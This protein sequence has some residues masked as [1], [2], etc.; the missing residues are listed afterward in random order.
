MLS[1]SP[2]LFVIATEIFLR[3]LEANTSSQSLVRAYADDIALVLQNIWRVVPAVAKLFVNLERIAGLRLKPNKCVLIPLWSC[4]L[5][6]NFHILL[7]EELPVWR[8]FAIS[9]KGKYLGVWL[10][11]GAVDTSWNEP[12]KKYMAQCEYIASL[13]L[14]MAS[15]AL[16]YR[17]FALPVLSFILQIYQIPEEALKKERQALRLLL[18]GPGNWLSTTAIHNLDLLFGMP[19]AFPS[20][21]V[22]SIAVKG[23]VAILE[24][25]DLAECKARISKALGG[26]D[27][28]IWHRW[29]PWFR[30]S[31]AY[32]ISEAKDT[33]DCMGWLL[34]AASQGKTR[35][36]ATSSTSFQSAL[37]RALR[38]RTMRTDLSSLLRQR[39]QR[40][41]PLLDT[42]IGIAAR[43]GEI[44]IEKLK[45]EVP[46][47]VLAALVRSW[48]NGWCTARRFQQGRGSC[49]LAEECAGEDSLEH[50]CRCA[51]SWSGARSRLRVDDSRRQLGRFLLLETLPQD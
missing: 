10:G 6:K 12:L 25:E 46:A 17:I 31:F 18:P 37:Y 2:L 42:P 39:L 40:W 30:N 23:R 7:K 51:W 20:L 16:L 45:K 11:P 3:A 36:S 49:W 14:G 24:V 22:M 26:D 21:T 8:D 34:P 32:C 9:S 41:A 33:L 50:Y 48:F 38:Q 5:G 44:V 29:T 35:K 1:L 47:C 43:R 15:T 13:K 27:A 28:P 4:D 19:A